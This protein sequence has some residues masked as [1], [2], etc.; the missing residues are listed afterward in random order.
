MLA[1]KRGERRPLLSTPGGRLR[2]QEVEAG[3][4]HLT[5]SRGLASDKQVGRQ[6]QDPSG[7][8]TLQVTRGKEMSLS[9]DLGHYYKL[10]KSDSNAVYLLSN[11]VYYLSTLSG[12]S[13]FPRKLYKVIL[14]C[15][16]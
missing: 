6:Q 9:R 13:F 10:P 3:G 16:Q 14:A 1:V 2:R 15:Q 7:R 5:G 8:N 12:N 11:S 4:R